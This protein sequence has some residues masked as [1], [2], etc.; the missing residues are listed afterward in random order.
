MKKSK[1]ITLLAVSALSV[2][3]LTACGS[4]ND[5]SD[6]T[7]SSS[8]SADAFTGATA[9]TTDFATLEKGFGADGAWLNAL[10][11]DVDA[12]G[13]TLT[14][15]GVF[16][17]DGQVAREIA[18]YK[19]GADHK[20]EALYTLTVDKLEVKSPGFMIS[21]GTVKGDVVVEAS[22]F[23]FEGTG[24]IDGNLTFATEDLK[25]AFEANADWVKAVSGKISVDTSLKAVT[26]KGGSINVA[27]KGGKVSYNFEGNGADTQAGATTG[28]TD[29]DVVT[30]G[31]SAKGAWLIA[32]T[33]D[34]DGSGKEITVDGTFMNERGAIQRTLCM[35]G[36]DKNRAVT[37]V[38]TLT[39]DKLIIKSPQFDFEGGNLKG[40]VYVA[41]GASIMSRNMKDPEGKDIRSKIE[42]NLYFATED[43]LNTYK[44]L[45]ENEQFEVSGE[46][47]VKAL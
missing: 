39:V 11:G 16:V 29:L 15:D 12:S 37:D 23:G 14:V 31:L 32:T 40:D 17:G 7:P 9:G 2:G 44:E 22:G 41:E 20:P 6:K 38:Y 45:P 18:L 21:Q 8:K 28:T 35:I 19:S 34:I 42:G 33:G 24:K 43:Q 26:V 46:V 47:A 30:K 3:F 4:S 36:Q 13:K 27:A 1:L 25:S 5:S 10:T